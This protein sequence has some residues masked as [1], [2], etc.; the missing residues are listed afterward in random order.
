MQTLKTFHFSP[1]H[2][3]AVWVLF[4]P[5]V[6]GWA[7]VR[8]E[9]VCPGCISETVRCRKFI[10]GSDIGWGCWCAASWSD[11]DLTFGLAIVTLT[12]KILSGLYLR[13]RKV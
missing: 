10:L 11:L 8:Q 6:P 5:M 3:R 9:I 4:S 2:L 12:F 1:Q 13:N 7:G